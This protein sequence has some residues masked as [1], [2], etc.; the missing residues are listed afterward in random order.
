MGG[1]GG[2]S[3]WVPQLLHSLLPYICH[4]H[5]E[6][7]AHTMA[8][9]GLLDQRPAS[10][11]APPT[12]VLC[13]TGLAATER[14]ALQ[15]AIATLTDV[16]YDGDLTDKTT[17]LIIA[18]PAGHE[19]EKLKVAKSLGL[20]IVLPSWVHDSV[21]AGQT[22]L[23]LLP[24]YVLP[25][26]GEEP[27][28]DENASARSANR[29]SRAVLS[30]H[31]PLALLREAS[32]RG[33]LWLNPTA[34]DQPTISLCGDEFAL[35]SPTG[36]LRQQGVAFAA[37]GKHSLAARAAG[38][39]GGSSPVMLPAAVPLPA[40][41][42]LGRAYTLRELLF[43]LHCA[44]KSHADYFLAC[45]AQQ[46][47]P[48][49]LLDKKMLLAAVMPSSPVKDHRASLSKGVLSLSRVAAN[50]ATPAGMLAGVPIGGRAS[51]RSAASSSRLSSAPTMRLQAREQVAPLSAAATY[52]IKKLAGDGQ[53]TPA[54][55]APSSV[56]EPDSADRMGV[57]ERAALLQQL[58]EAAEERA[59][60]NAQVEHL[61]SALREERAA[62]AADCQYY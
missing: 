40:M 30:V 24:K 22:L 33:E 43:A 51:G 61:T 11:M 21:A 4:S 1:A 17:H 13:S 52:A 38:G 55:G 31:D 62:A 45:V 15:A 48:V 47:E 20:P 28:A 25:P 19:S 26:H 10:S 35:D 54:S 60:L 18:K 58:R 50:A 32:K 29:Q 7:P 46:I 56:A 16:T 3:M 23:P 5:A 2:S 53:L 59:K 12:T 8:S 34:P 36:F 44:S 41:A 42:S 49:L 14:K 37:A 27:L 9:T 57:E 6:K 39:E